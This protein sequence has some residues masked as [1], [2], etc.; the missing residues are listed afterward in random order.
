MNFD[1][2]DGLYSYL[3][4]FSGHIIT[5]NGIKFLNV[6]QY[7]TYYKFNN[8]DPPYAASILKASSS[9]NLIRLANSRR[10]KITPSWDS[11]KYD[12]MKNGYKLKFQQYPVLKQCLVTLTAD[13]LN[14]I[15]HPY[16]N[17]WSYHGKNMLGSMLMEL[18]YEYM[19]TGVKQLPVPV[20]MKKITPI[21][22]QKT[23]N[24]TPIVKPALPNNVLPVDNV[25]QS[26]VDVEKEYNKL[27]QTTVNNAWLGR[28]KLNKPTIV[29]QDDLESMELRREQELEQE[30]ES[31]RI[32]YLKN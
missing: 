28:V 1:D 8:T 32:D 12:V 3:S 30:L 13:G 31:E 2:N 29:K 17:Y 5:E 20:P 16:M 25:L 21:V 22:K 10:N 6:Y 24:V 11:K 23:P 14:Y 19:D 27:V 15:E 7:Y 26:V 18:K 4:P 9:D